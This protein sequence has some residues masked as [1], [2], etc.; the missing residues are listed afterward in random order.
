M[1]YVPL[2]LPGAGWRRPG[3]GGAREDIQARLR[4]VPDGIVLTPGP[5]GPRGPGSPGAS[6][7]RGPGQGEGGRGILYRRYSLVLMCTVLMSR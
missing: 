1:V 6:T 5:T 7:R 2:S 3:A 4:R